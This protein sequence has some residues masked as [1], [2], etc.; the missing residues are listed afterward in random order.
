MLCTRGFESHPRRFWVFFKLFIFCSKLICNYSVAVV[1]CNV[2][3]VRRG[4]RVVKAIGLLN[5]LMYVAYNYSGCFSVFGAT[6]DFSI[7][8]VVNVR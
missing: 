4:G 5:P 1:Y 8:C 7:N 3:N 6:F 2:F